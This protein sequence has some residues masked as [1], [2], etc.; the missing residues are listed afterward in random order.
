MYTALCNATLVNR[1]DAIAWVQKAALELGLGF[2]PDT[3]A[4]EYVNTE[5]NQPTFTAAEAVAFDAVR[6]KA[7]DLL[8]DSIYDYGLSIQQRLLRG[9]LPMDKKTAEQLEAIVGGEA[10]ERNGEWV[11]TVNEEDGSIVL[12]TGEG[13]FQYESDEALDADK[14]MATVNATIPSAEDLWV[15][16]DT[17]GNVFFQNNKLERGWRYEDD[18]RREAM[19]LQSR[20]EGKF[21]VVRKS[22]ADV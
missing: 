22:D 21:Q 14:P 19:A 11:V 8:G 5:T 4:A 18:A 20:G 17:K 9:T 2:H 7:F 1:Q 3:P 10:W 15:L 6:E 12:Y 16:V 13:I